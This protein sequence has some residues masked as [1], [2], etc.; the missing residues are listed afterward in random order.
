MMIKYITIVL[1]IYSGQNEGNVL[2]LLNNGTTNSKWTLAKDKD[3][4]KVYTRQAE[5][6]KIKEF[7]AVTTVNTNIKTLETLIDKVNEYPDWQANIESSMVLK[8]VDQ[9]AKY[10]YYTTDVPW[11]IKDRD[12]VLQSKKTVSE[13]GTVVYEIFSSPD[14]I[15]E[16]E[17]FLR[18]RAAK[19]K[20]QLV[21]MEGDKI[22]ITYQ[23]YGDPA[24]N[25]PNWLINMFVV[26]GPFE[27]LRNLKG[28]VEP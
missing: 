13:N 22:E 2:H 15:K 20:W 10:I 27:T 7:K 17:D 3:D 19:G 16:K 4:V 12:I 8:K 5:G 18:I 6:S 23:F 25:L 14:Y 28:L 11:P 24:G 26:D 9:N 1:L 21:P